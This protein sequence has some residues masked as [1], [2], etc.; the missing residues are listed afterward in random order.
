MA[1]SRPAEFHRPICYFASFHRA[2][3]RRGQ[4]HGIPICCNPSIFLQWRYNI[5]EFQACTVPYQKHH[6]FYCNLDRTRIVITIDAD[7]ICTWLKSNSNTTILI[8]SKHCFLQIRGNIDKLTSPRIRCKIIAY[9][10]FPTFFFFQICVG[11]Q[12]ILSAE[13]YY[14]SIISSQKSS[15]ICCS[16]SLKRMVRRYNR[17]AFSN[18]HIVA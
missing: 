15:I 17:I 3:N 10:N 16:F 13:A 9:G 18:R 12:N 6:L 2:V 4:C 14:S 7:V 11:N 1:V 8:F 5:E